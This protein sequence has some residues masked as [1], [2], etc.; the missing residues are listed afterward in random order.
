METQVFSNSNASTGLNKSAKERKKRQNRKNI[1]GNNVNAANGNI[2]P[3]HGFLENFSAFHNPNNPN[4]QALNL[5]NP[6]QNQPSSKLRSTLEGYMSLASNPN[7]LPMFP[8]NF[9]NNNGSHV[10]FV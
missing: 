1:Q 6:Q 9:S 8:L 10:S 7:D 4:E 2:N 3:T 5:V